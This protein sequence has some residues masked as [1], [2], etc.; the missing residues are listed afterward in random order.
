MRTKIE[1]YK[2]KIFIH[3]PNIYCTPMCDIHRNKVDRK[4]YY[5]FTFK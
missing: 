1:Q 5:V 4:L 3:S 2:L